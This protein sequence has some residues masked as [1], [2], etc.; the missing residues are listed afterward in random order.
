MQ[1]DEQCFDEQEHEQ[2]AA[3]KRREARF[4]AALGRIGEPISLSLVLV[5]IG[6]SVAAAGASGPISDA[7]ARKGRLPCRC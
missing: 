2:L 5:S 6:A 1:K 4:A 3:T 7:L